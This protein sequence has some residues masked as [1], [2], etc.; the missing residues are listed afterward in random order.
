MSD[1]WAIQVNAGAVEVRKPK[2]GCSY[3]VFT[4]IFRIG[5]VNHRLTK[6]YSKLRNF[7]ARLIAVANNPPHFPPKSWLFQKTTELKFKIK[8]KAALL[9]YFEA[10]V[11][12]PNILK[13]EIF[14]VLLNLPDN[15]RK[16]MVKIAEDLE[17]KKYIIEHHFSGNHSSASENNHS[18]LRDNKWK[19][20]MCAAGSGMRTLSGGTPPLAGDHIK[21]T[22]QDVDSSPHSCRKQERIN[23]TLKDIHIDFKMSFPEKVQDDDDLHIEIEELKQHP[24]MMK[25]EK[26]IKDYR[27]FTLEEVLSDIVDLS[28]PQRSAKRAFRWY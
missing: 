1:A 4:F 13:L 25:Y 8:R 5:A 19:L 10:I 23:A 3:C 2:R 18:P 20:G 27:I 12:Q 28:A 7:H 15:L 21:G 26:A 24:K 22:P 14:H 9:K 11:R 16:K 6:R 17:S